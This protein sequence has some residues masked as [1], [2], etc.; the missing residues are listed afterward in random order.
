MQD[1]FLCKC[2]KCYSHVRNVQLTE[3][4]VVLMCSIKLKWMILKIPHH[5]YASTCY[6]TNLLQL[7]KVFIFLNRIESH[8]LDEME[9]IS[10]KDMKVT[11]SIEEY[12]NVC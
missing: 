2:P 6:G 12:A 3:L 9:V 11:D 5:T 1:S 8:R 10:V 4:I 7:H